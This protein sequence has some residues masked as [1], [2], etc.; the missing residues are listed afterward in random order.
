MRSLLFATAA[1]L[2]FSSGYAQRRPPNYSQD[3]MPETSFE[4]RDKDIGG[5]YADPEA[6]CQMFHV[7]VKMGPSEAI[8]DFRFLCPNDTMFDQENQ[9]CA[10]WF[11]IDCEASTL[12][13]SKSFD[14]FRVGHGP[15][16]DDILQRAPEPVK[17]VSVKQA[18]RRPQPPKPAEDEFFRTASSSDIH[19]GRDEEDESP[20]AP[21]LSVPAPKP[22]APAPK[23]GQRLVRR[24][25][26]RRLRPVQAQQ[27]EFTSNQQQ[28]VVQRQETVTPRVVVS[29]APPKDL[30][31]PLSITVTEAPAATT[32]TFTPEE[33]VNPASTISPTTYAAFQA[34]KN[35]QRKTSGAPGKKVNLAN[36]SP[37]PR[38]QNEFTTPASV[39][40]AENQQRQEQAVINQQANNFNQQQ[41]QPKPSTNNPNN[42]NQQ[43]Q[44]Q[45]E[46]QVANNFDQQQNQQRQPQPAVNNF[47]QQQQ[48]Q[49]QPQVSNNVN[50]QQ[51]RQP[52]VAS[53]FNQQQQSQQRQPQQANN[54]NQQQNQQRQPQPAVN[55]FN[56]Q[57]QR[58]PQVSNNFN[59]Q[60]QRQPQ[61]ASNFNQQQQSQQRQPQQVN[62]FNQQQQ[63]QQR[64]PQ[65][66]SDLNQQQRQTT[67]SANN[68]NHQ[69][70]N[71]RQQPSA[72]NFNQQQ[73]Q[74]RQQPAV[75]NFNQQTRQ[76]Q[77]A[78]N[79]QQAQN[80]N[81]Q[82]RQ[83]S[84]QQ[85]GNLN[86]QQRSP[87]VQLPLDD[88]Q[89][90]N[91]K[92]VNQQSQQINSQKSQISEQRVNQQQQFQSF[93]TFSSQ[94]QSS[95]STFSSPNPS[96]FNPSTVSQFINPSTTVAPAAA[97]GFQNRASVSPKP[98]QL[99]RSQRPRENDFSE[100][101]EDEL[102]RT[103]HSSSF[104]ASDLNAIQRSQANSQST[105]GAD[106]TFA[107]TKPP[108]SISSPKPFSK[109]STAFVAQTSRVTSSTTFAPRPST[110]PRPI[111]SS[112]SRPFVTE[113]IPSSPSSSSFAP[114]ST[115]QPS[116][117]KKG[118]SDY[119]YAYYDDTPFD[120][121]Y[122]GV[123]HISEFSRTNAKN[124]G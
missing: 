110:F 87:P 12:Y 72:N 79:Q 20:S 101:K 96:S 39:K 53:N 18:S 88:F 46:P 25:Q 41:R 5:Y 82:Q 105:F 56:Q 114:N 51:Q 2:L 92:Q 27:N 6:D 86:N 69:Q 75:N 62:N 112:T 37:L 21:K 10:N 117:N 77:Q 33:P 22:A 121:E 67:Q 115:D 45:R 66:A 32:N 57:Q 95:A 120:H 34:R 15:A 7:C 68:F 38:V 116:R 73:T 19:R 50:Q 91:N 123:D 104:R 76:P 108:V 102:L 1:V 70:Q 47:N 58:Q 99:R 44:N 65:P 48:Q 98:F 3:N 71:Q 83:P 54:F 24:K 43:Q 55:N 63:N 26:H 60:Q 64:Q 11:D 122:E 29:K 61:A 52:Q 89:K 78:N 124:Q 74:Q 93:N 49:R 113:T 81:N 118:N 90:L 16:S 30:Q 97:F 42:L 107:P 40:L 119:D 4:C 28:A 8:Q 31:P 14:L 13:Y 36:R 106:K 59:Q 109:P 103:A 35:S 9:I 84:Q 80:F 85:P 17:F 94:Q 111:S 100:E 23:P